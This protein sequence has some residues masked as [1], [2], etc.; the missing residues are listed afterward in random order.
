MSV[1]Q[2]Y[3]QIAEAYTQVTERAMYGVPKWLAD[4]LP[5]FVTSEP[6]N[7]AD[8]ACANGLLGKILRTRFPEVQITGIDI[9]PRMIEQAELFGYQSGSGFLCPYLMAVAKLA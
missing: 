6:S 5:R 1:I 7:T 3:D 2:L 9:T 8:L 4:A